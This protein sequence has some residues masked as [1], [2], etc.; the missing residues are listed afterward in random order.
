MVKFKLK[1]NQAFILNELKIIEGKGDEP[2]MVEPV[3]AQTGVLSQ[4]NDTVTDIKDSA[5]KAV[6]DVGGS[7]Q[8]NLDMLKPQ[9]GGDVNAPVVMPSGQY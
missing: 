8:K 5:Q 7:D 1:T 3:A 2:K 9:A 4:I 6:E